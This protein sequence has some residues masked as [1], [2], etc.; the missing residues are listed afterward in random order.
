MRK[1]I[2]L[3]GIEIQPFDKFESKVLGFYKNNNNLYSGLAFA[4]SSIED[5]RKNQKYYYRNGSL[6]RRSYQN[7][8]L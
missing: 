5:N 4:G 2:N 8:F 1:E 7:K 6:F 3:Y